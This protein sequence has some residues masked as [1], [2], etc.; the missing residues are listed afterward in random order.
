MEPD[1]T[2]METILS[3]RESGGNHTAEPADNG[4]LV[5][6]LTPANCF[7]HLV[8]RQL[9][10]DV[11]GGGLLAEPVRR[12]RSGAGGVPDD[13]VAPD[14]AWVGALDR[15]CRAAALDDVAGD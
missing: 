2:V 14:R 1:V 5:V 13:V 12:H 9:R 3:R 11:D 8:R 10:Q 4:P 6:R 7:Q 15:S